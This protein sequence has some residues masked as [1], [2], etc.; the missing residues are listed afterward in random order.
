M[1]GQRQL[2]SNST[3]EMSGLFRISPVRQQFCLRGISGA[4]REKSPHGHENEDEG[5]HGPAG[6]AYVVDLSGEA[7]AEVLQAGHHVAVEQP[8]CE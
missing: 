4:E 2:K 7:G 1:I 5:T 3:I 8:L 6:G